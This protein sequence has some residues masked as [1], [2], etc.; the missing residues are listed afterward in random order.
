MQ[1]GTFVQ[2]AKQINWRD[3]YPT[4]PFADYAICPGSGLI[5]GIASAKG[6]AYSIMVD[7][8]LYAPVALP[9]RVSRYR[10]LSTFRR[11]FTPET[12]HAKE[13]TQGSGC[14]C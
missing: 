3:T 11:Y 2:L 13:A 6:R 5:F 12:H 7:G 8:L 9:S 4:R 1:N 14:P 10:S